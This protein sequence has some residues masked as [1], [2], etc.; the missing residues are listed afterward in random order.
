MLPG[1]NAVK[2]LFADLA[3]LSLR[4]V[5]KA[6]CG[7]D[8]KVRLVIFESYERFTFCCGVNHIIYLG[9]ALLALWIR[10]RWYSW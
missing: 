3:D 4:R 1:V 9:V 5:D 8:G 2:E 6:T 7:V 10:A